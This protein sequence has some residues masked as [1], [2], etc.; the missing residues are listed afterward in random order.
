MAICRG[1]IDGIDRIW[2]GEKVISSGESAGDRVITDLEF[3]GGAEAGGGFDFT[4]GIRIGSRT[5]TVHPYIATV[6]TPTP[7]Y[8]STCFAIL[9]DG[10]SAFCWWLYWKQSAIE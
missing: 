9:F 6:Q 2:M 3:F 8:R 1:P 4:L 7:A 10:S 5:Q